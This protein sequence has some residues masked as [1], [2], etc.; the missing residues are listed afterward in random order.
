MSPKATK[1]KRRL[2]PPELKSEAM[3]IQKKSGLY[4]AP[5]EPQS[6]A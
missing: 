4:R 6:A 5:H 1:R 2:F 3:L